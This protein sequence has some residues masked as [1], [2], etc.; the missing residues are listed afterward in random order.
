[1]ALTDTAGLRE[2]KDPIEEEGIRRVWERVSE[3]DLVIV[4]IDGS[5]GLTGDDV[6]I[7]D[8]CRQQEF[9]LVINKSD[10]P[11]VVEEKHLAALTPGT[12]APIWISAKEGLGISEL[13]E[14]IYGH[15]LT[16]VQRAGSSQIVTNIRHKIAIEKT[17]DLLSRAKDAILQGLSPELSAFEIRQSLESLGEI[18][19]ETV[20]EEVLHRIFSTF[21]IGK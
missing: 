12:R 11:H 16:D 8:G 9:F 6:K 5:E 14:A 13:K 15:A 7:I 2:P 10:L 17:S 4:L 20:T 3:T 21:C 18:A 19:G 1:V